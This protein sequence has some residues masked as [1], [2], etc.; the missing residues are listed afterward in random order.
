MRSS[1]TLLLTTSSINV[2]NI[3]LSDEFDWDPSKN[4]FEISLMEEEYRKSSNFHRCINIV[5]S[6]V[7]CPPPTIQCRYYMVIHEFDIPMAN[8]S[9]GLA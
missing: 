7:P 9:I 3:L 1:R 5:D 6:I 4:V 8:V 2:K